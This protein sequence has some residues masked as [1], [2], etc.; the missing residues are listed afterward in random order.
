M[1]EQSNATIA[2]F[3]VRDQ[4]FESTRRKAISYHTI[5]YLDRGGGWFELATFS[6]LGPIEFEAG[7]H[8]INSRRRWKD[9]EEMES[10]GEEICL[11]H[12]SHVY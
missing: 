11:K 1:V 6:K 8:Q 2:R 4:W 12:R 3:K 9:E 7:S 10:Q 5:S